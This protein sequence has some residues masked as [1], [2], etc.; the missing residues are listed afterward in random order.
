MKEFILKFTQAPFL[1][2]L[3][4][5]S[6]IISLILSIIL[7]GLTINIKKKLKSFSQIKRY[8]RL[9]ENYKNQLIACKNMIMKDEVINREVIT[10]ILTQIHNFSHFKHILTLEDRIR[11]YSIE[12]HLKKDLSEI[13]KGKLCNQLSY[14]ISRYNK[15]EEEF[16]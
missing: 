1:S 6:S 2:G 4:A 14:F 15:K 13:S 8:N 10:D 12:I 3:A 11:I 5:L 7:I 16:I 9:R